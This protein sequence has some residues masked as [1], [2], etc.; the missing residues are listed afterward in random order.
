MGKTIIRLEGR[1][2]GQQG[3]KR[4]FMKRKKKRQQVW[5]ITDV[6]GQG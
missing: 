5:A 6:K 4:G 3:E 2:N 1:L